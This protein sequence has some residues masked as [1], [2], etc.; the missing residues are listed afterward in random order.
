M[1]NKLD[2]FVSGNNDLLSKN[3]DL[4]EEIKKYQL[5]LD[6][7]EEQIKELE[8]KAQE[9]QRGITKVYYFNGLIR[10]TDGPSISI[11]NKLR[12][13]Y[14]RMVNLDQERTYEELKAVCY[15][16][17]EL[18]PDWPTPYLFLGVSLVN[19][20]EIKKANDQLEY[21]LKIAPNNP[22]LGYNDY[23]DQAE[24]FINLAKSQ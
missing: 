14:K 2:D 18:N 16:Q 24:Q 7:K 15:E 1:Q 6:K 9:A 22:T 23:R 4:L 12:E 21:F 19:T 10:K 11:D 5:D 13:V 17:I 20:G 3:S 8:A